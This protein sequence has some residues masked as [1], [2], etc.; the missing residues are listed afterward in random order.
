M[1]PAMVIEGGYLRDILA[2]PQALADTLA[3]LEI[4]APLAETGRRLAAG[5]FRRVALTGMGG[6]YWALY[7]LYLDLLRR[8][9][10]ATLMETSELIHYLPS[11]LDSN[12][13]LIV[14]SQSGRSAEIVRALDVK[15]PDCSTLAITNDPEAPLARRA[16]AVVST[17][18][19]EEFTVSCKT[20]VATVMAAAWLG[21]V[22]AGR[23][24][25][26]LAQAAPAVSAYLSDWREHVRG[27]AE[28][29]GGARHF[30]YLGRGDSLAAAGTAGLITKESTHLHAEGMSA[31]AF[32]HGPMEMVDGA[33]F[34]LVFAG[35]PATGALNARLAEDIRRAGGRAVLAGEE[36]EAGAFRLP[37][38]PPAV[39]P[40]V[41]ILPVEMITLALAAA[42]G[43][44]AGR[45]ERASKVTG[46]E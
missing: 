34:A 3:G 44:E 27:A 32:R 37:R 36:A 38:V 35:D 4:S 7:P 29:L 45:F 16:D 46:T 21:N 41:E 26:E 9:H 24:S 12:T 20:Y 33:V 31:A 40:I 17:R 14:A 28:A 2:Q 30:F 39:R 5:G 23:S 10:A 11:A 8:G 13:L 42:H 43:R 22:L 19:G 18:A 6:S 25:G 15:Q 1:E